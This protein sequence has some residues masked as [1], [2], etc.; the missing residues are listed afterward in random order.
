[1]GENAASQR[2]R[3][4]EFDVATALY[5]QAVLQGVAE[6]Q[7]ALVQLDHERQRVAAAVAVEEA[8]RMRSKATEA[9]VRLGLADGFQQAD[10]RGAALQAS[11]DTLR[12]GLAEQVA[13]IALFTSFGGAVLPPASP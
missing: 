1:G 2:A 10:A 4:A 5:R 13:Y 8:V 9:Q 7:S 12:A 3:D 11:R 6:A